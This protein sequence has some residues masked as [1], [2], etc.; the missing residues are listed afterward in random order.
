MLNDKGQVTSGKQE[1]EDDCSLELSWDPEKEFGASGDDDLIARNMQQRVQR[2]EVSYRDVMRM[3][4]K[5]G[6]ALGNRPGSWNDGQPY[7]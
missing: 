4:P 2:Q 3:R 7:V 6:L 1:E 5:W